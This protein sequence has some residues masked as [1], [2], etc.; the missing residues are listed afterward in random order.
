[1]NVQSNIIEET[2]LRQRVWYGHVEEADKESE[3]LSKFWSGYQQNRE[4]NI[5]RM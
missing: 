5:Y 4:K 1:M 2:Q 3:F